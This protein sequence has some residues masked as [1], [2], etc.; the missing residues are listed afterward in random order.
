M[1]MV[2]FYDG[3]RVQY[4]NPIRIDDC[5]QAMS[6]CEY[7]AFGESFS[8]GLLYHLISSI[9]SEKIANSALHSNYVNDKFNYDDYLPWIYISRCFI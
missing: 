3:A 1:R 7:G 4:H 6:H 9:L 2:E 8:Y 5:V